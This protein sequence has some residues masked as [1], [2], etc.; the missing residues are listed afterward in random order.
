M[1][2]KGIWKEASGRSK[3]TFYGHHPP[4][5]LLNP[6]SR[7]LIQKQ[8]GKGRKRDLFRNS[9]EPQGCST[10]TITLR[11]EATTTPRGKGHALPTSALLPGLWKTT[12]D[13]E[14]SAEEWLRCSLPEHQHLAHVPACQ[15]PMEAQPCLCCSHPAWSPGPW[16]GPAANAGFCVC[17]SPSFVWH[18]TPSC[19]P[20]KQCC[21][22]CISPQ[23]V[24]SAR[25]P[26][27]K[28]F[29][30]DPHPAG[31]LQSKTTNSNSQTDRGACSCRSSTR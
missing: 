9:A 2:P 4:S 31:A 11:A 12:S 19:Q 6:P 30:L 26:R 16:G 1:L 24:P 7:L 27:K 13:G 14:S 22:P 15:P 29:L 10:S 21:H 17:S 20:C 3:S 18:E 5:R 23:A 8:A 28:L 25:A